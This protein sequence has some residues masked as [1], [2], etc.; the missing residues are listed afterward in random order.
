M[1]F[2]CM[3]CA[4]IG[5]FG[6]RDFKNN[7]LHHCNMIGLLGMGRAIIDDNVFLWFLTSIFV[8]FMGSD[9]YGRENSN[10]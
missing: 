6:P 1:F 2:L 10:I 4:L 9:K 7:I 5:H 8:P 3:G